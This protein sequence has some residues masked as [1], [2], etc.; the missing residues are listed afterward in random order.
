MKQP[1][2]LKLIATAK[3]GAGKSILTFIMA[4]KHRNAVILDLDDAT[5]TSSQQLS[6]R[7]PSLVSFLDPMTER[8]DRSAFNN[9]WESIAEADNEFFIADLGASVAEQLPMYFET[10]T[11]EVIAGLLTL[12]SIDLQI[13]CVVGGGNNFKATM[14]YLLKTLNATHGCF[15][16][17]VAHNRHFPMSEEQRNTFEIFIEENRLR[18]IS[19]DLL[20]DKGDMALRI[21]QSVLLAGKGISGLSPFKAIYFKTSIEDLPTL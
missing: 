18:C 9:L 16:I 4:E 1:K 15:E 8:I 10:S 11:P 20:T 13:I 17:V 19:F 6:Y 3:G 12:Y 2:K 5:K 21:A 7:S 14:E